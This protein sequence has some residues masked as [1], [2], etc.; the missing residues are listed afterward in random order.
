MTMMAWFIPFFFIL[1]SNLLENSCKGS[2]A[3]T[4]LDLM[5]VRES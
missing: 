4:I 1:G 5:N 3:V 2:S